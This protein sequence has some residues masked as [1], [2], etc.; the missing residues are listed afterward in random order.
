M[1]NLGARRL[2]RIAYTYI[3]A[4]LF[5]RRPEK[6]LEDFIIN[7]FGKELYST[8]FKDYTE[9]VWGVP[10]NRISP[11]WGA[12]RIKGLSILKALRHAVKQAIGGVNKSQDYRQ[13]QT[14]TSLI[15]QF[16][17]P[18]Y[19]PG[20]MWSEVAKEIHRLGG[21]I[22]FGCEVTG[23]T[24]EHGQVMSVT[25]RR[26]NGDT[27]V[28]PGDYVLSSM[29]V[30]E[31]IE[32]MND[33]PTNVQRVAAGLQY[34]D[35]ITV[36]VL[37]TKMI[38]DARQVSSKRMLPDNWIYIQEKDVKL[39]RVQI[40]NNWSPRMVENPST[41]WLGLEYFCNEDDDLWS[42]SNE[43]LKH[44]AISELE[45]INL[46]ASADV[47]DSH[48]E[49]VKKAYPAYFGTYG[50]FEHIRK[51]VDNISNLFLIGRNGMHRY[52]NQDHSMLTGREAVKKIKEKNSDKNDL[53]SVNIDE[54]YHEGEGNT[55]S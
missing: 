20:Q 24:A 40:F 30:R 42:M 26:K 43:E 13:K 46:I 7:R 3:G 49:K 33:V 37:V 23:L 34:R 11:A 1:R 41:V 21:E 50:E 32:G 17:Y 45:K 25:V 18:K 14:Q 8:F 52:N 27:D 54:Q 16:L 36:G 39:G 55:G 31:L 15:E 22:R 12:Q 5:P 47:I 19:G 48:V 53:W 6:N 2:V 28:V 44:L 4:L 38:S 29:P 51:F 10:C 35:F 9:K